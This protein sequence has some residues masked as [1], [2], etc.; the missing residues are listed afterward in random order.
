MQ[1]KVWSGTDWARTAAEGVSVVGNAKKECER[2]RR[3]ASDGWSYGGVMLE[4]DDVDASVMP[5]LSGDWPA[6][7]TP[8]EVVED[9]PL[10]FGVAFFLLLLEGVLRGPRG[11]P[12]GQP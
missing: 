6:S 9:A 1:G 7:T 11:L 2:E 4:E 5:L 12:L 3:R 8:L 10:G